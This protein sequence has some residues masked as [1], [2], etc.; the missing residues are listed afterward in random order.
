MQVVNEV[1]ITVPDT[2]TF[3]F[4]IHWP[5]PLDTLQLLQ[6]G[7]TERPSLIFQQVWVLPLTLLEDPSKYMFYVS[8]CS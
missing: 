4:H 3:L 1:S 6:G 5:F 8:A 7:C 2:Y